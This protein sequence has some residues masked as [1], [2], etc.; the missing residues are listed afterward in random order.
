MTP[1]LLFSIVF[2]GGMILVWLFW[3]RIPDGPRTGAE[4]EEAESEEKGRDDGE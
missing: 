3:D 2:F 4:D 1:G